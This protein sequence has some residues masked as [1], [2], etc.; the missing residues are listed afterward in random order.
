MEAKE[1][2]TEDENEKLQQ[3]EALK[4]ESAL[5]IYCRLRPDD[6]Q[7][8]SAEV[9]LEQKSDT[10]IELRR[11]K[12]IFKQEYT[13]EH[14]F[15]SEASQETIFQQIG[16]P[17]ID[18]LLKGQN[19]L[20]F[21]Y[22]ATGSGKSYTVAGQAE[23]PG[24]VPNIIDCLF[25]VL[26]SRLN[27]KCH[28]EP[29]TNNHYIIN[30]RFSGGSLLEPE[31]VKDANFWSNRSCTQSSDAANLTLSTSTLE[32]ISTR[33]YSVFISFVEIYNNYIYDLL[34]QPEV[35]VIHWRRPPHKLCHDALK[36][37]YVQGGSEV[38]A[39]SAKQAMQLFLYGLSN[40]QTA[41]T[42]LNDCSSRS[43]AVFTLKLVSYDVAKC[44]Q[45]GQVEDAN[46]LDVNQLSVVDLAGVERT[47]RTKA[48]GG[49]LTEASNINKSLL[50]LRNCFNVMRLNQ[51][52]KQAAPIPYR[53]D[54]LT[55]LLKSFFE[56][57]LSQISMIICVKPSLADL[58]DSAQVLS[59]AEKAQS[60]MIKQTS[61]T[62]RNEMKSEEMRMT[63]MFPKEEA[64]MDALAIQLNSFTHTFPPTEIISDSTALVSSEHFT[65][66][67]EHIEKYLDDHP[68]EASKMLDNWQ[69]FCRYTQPCSISQNNSLFLHSATAK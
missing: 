21:A 13:F 48:S 24:L 6:E 39:K 22:G 4:E 58:D 30:T 47:R 49:T 12:S 32:R 55:F 56:G 66:F 31:D 64:E 42:R 8:T 1:Y 16:L 26:A 25:S 65:V 38:E 61:L 54:K 11:P 27:N 14:V 67:V 51:T 9:T 2:Q 46:D 50:S 29:D 15:G 69:Q 20:I 17:K 40:R 3:C 37:V 36:A 7:T 44:A 41:A 43:H 5:K 18:S 19:G 10:V 63:K 57:G 68:K 53:T 52:A 62:E 33:R 23:N 34:E 28:I 60:V 35:G 45:S 59:F